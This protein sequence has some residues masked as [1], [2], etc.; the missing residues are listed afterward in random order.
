MVVGGGGDGGWWGGVRV[1]GGSWVVKYEA[2]DGGKGFPRKLVVLEFSS[3]FIKSTHFLFSL[4]FLEY[5]SHLFFF[6]IFLPPFNLPSILIHHFTPLS[7]H[8]FFIHLL[9]PPSI[10]R[11]WLPRV[12]ICS[13]TRT[14]SRGSAS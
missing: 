10:R 2:A 12:T 9:L 4:H 1:V 13:Q 8:C 11:S 6:L 7:N 3:F 14:T 5:L